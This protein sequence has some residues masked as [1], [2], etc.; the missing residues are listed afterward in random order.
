MKVL[1]YRG[2]CTEDECLWSA[3]GT[4][5]LSETEINNAYDYYYK[6]ATQEV[7]TFAK[8]NEYKNISKMNKEILYYT[9]RI[10]PEQK[11]TAGEGVTMTSVMKDLSSTTFCVPIIDAH[12]PVAY[13][14][15]NEVHW[16]DKVAKHR[17]VET[18]YRYVLKSC[19]IINGRELVK[20]FSKNCERCRY[21]AK[22]TID[23]EM[24]PVS[25]YNLTIAPA[26][27]ITQVDL[28]GPFAA[29]SPHNKRTTVK[30]YFAIYCCSVTST[31]S[32]KVMEDY[33]AASFIQ[34]F[35][36][37]S[38]NAGVPKILLSDTGS[39]LV[40]GY[41]EMQIDFTDLRNQL[42]HQESV[43]F[44]IV[45]V[46]G[47]NF[48]GKVERVI[49]EV[50]LSI[51]R[52]YENQRFSILQWETVGEEIANAINDMPLALRNIVSDFE[53]MDLVTPNR[54]KLGRNNNRSPVGPLYVTNDPTRFFTANE[55]IFSTWFEAWL[56]SHVH[57]L[58]PQP[59]WYVTSHH[60]K[61]GDVVLFLKK[62]GKLNTTYQYGIVKEAKS[63]RDG[64]VRKVTVR[65]R[66][67]N[68][69]FDRETCRAV[70]QLIVIHRVDELNIIQELGKIAT[71]VDMKKSLNCSASP[72]GGV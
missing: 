72:P 61:E 18:V 20:L 39:Q 21:L 41:G 67:H 7:L 71:I 47:H 38:C 62:E 65:Y 45:P 58:M 35:I 6:K 59:K 50:K 31:V 56:T 15:V 52:C 44:E 53:E 69:S 26:F 40:K 30:I 1:L 57:K 64:I 10:L 2:L 12:S 68:E 25:K 17:G 8:E 13:S 37:F 29:Y 9:G 63:G 28:A 43:E 16:E 3:T 42:H 5:A 4:T 36:R 34:S 33:N 70:R 11:V 32:L 19:Y 51:E 66:N 27:Y 54:L 23:I 24:G 60:I 49:K 22:R 55:A 46:G 14:V 48:T